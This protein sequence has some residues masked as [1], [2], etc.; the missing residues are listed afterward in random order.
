[1]VVLKV[2]VLTHKETKISY[3]Q[4]CI[5]KSAIFS[6][7]RYDITRGNERVVR[8]VECARKDG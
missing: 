8:E 5:L 4:P 1:M 2:A 6:A 3:F 7:T